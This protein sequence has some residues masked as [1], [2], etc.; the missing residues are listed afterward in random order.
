MGDL[1]KTSNNLLLTNNM[2]LSTCCCTSGTYWEA[3]PCDAFILPGEDCH[4]WDQCPYDERRYINS[5]TRCQGTGVSICECQKLVVRD[6]SDLVVS[7]RVGNFGLNTNFSHA[8]GIFNTGNIIWSVQSTVD[9]SI[10]SGTFTYTD[11][12]TLGSLVD[13]LNNWNPGGL[14]NPITTTLNYAPTGNITKTF[15]TGTILLPSVGSTGDIQSNDSLLRFTWGTGIIDAPF[16]TSSSTF[17]SNLQEA[18]TSTSGLLGINVQQD[19]SN[20]SLTDKIFY[21]TFGGD[22]CGIRQDKLGLEYLILSNTFTPNIPYMVEGTY[23][24]GWGAETTNYIRVPSGDITCPYEDVSFVGLNGVDTG[25]AVFAS[26]LQCCPQKGCILG[27]NQNIGGSDVYK[28]DFA[29]L[30]NTAVFATG[31]FT[32]V[33]YK[34]SPFY[35]LFGKEGRFDRDPS[36]YNDYFMVSSC[37]YSTNSCD[38]D[39]P[40]DCVPELFTTFFNYQLPWGPFGSYTSGIEDTKHEAYKQYLLGNITAGQNYMAD[41][42]YSGWNYAPS[43]RCRTLGTWTSTTG[44]EIEFYYNRISDFYI[45][46]NPAYGDAKIGKI[47][48]ATLAS[49]FTLA[50]GNTGTGT[51][52][53]RYNV[54]GKTVNDFITDVNAI[55]TLSVSG[56]SCYV[57][58]FCGAAPS[59]SLN[60]PCSKINNLSCELFNRWKIEQGNNGTYHVSNPDFDL[61]D[62]SASTILPAPR[63]YNALLATEPKVFNVSS[64]TSVINQPPP[65]SRIKSSGIYPSNTGTIQTQYREYCRPFWTSMRGCDELVATVIKSPSTFDPTVTGFLMSVSGRNVVFTMYS[66]AT[67]IYTTG[68]PLDR[69]GSGYTDDNLIRD[70]NSWTMTYFADGVTTYH[71]LA[72]SSG[73]LPY[74]IYLDDSTWISGGLPSDRGIGTRTSNNYGFINNLKTFSNFDL[75]SGA[76]KRLTS[77]VKNL[78]YPTYDES[79]LDGDLPKCIPPTSPVEDNNINCEGDNIIDMGWLVTYGCNSYTCKTE[80]FIQAKRCSCSTMPVCYDNGGSPIYVDHPYNRDYTEDCGKLSQPTFYMCESNIHP[81]CTI[82]FLIKVPFQYVCA[83]GSTNCYFG[84]CFK[85][86]NTAPCYVA[87]CTTTGDLDPLQIGYSTTDYCEITDNSF[88]ENGYQGWCQYIDPNNLTRVRRRDIPRTWPPKSF[89]VERATTPFCTTNVNP[90]DLGSGPT[91]YDSIGPLWPVVPYNELIPAGYAKEGWPCF[92][93]NLSSNTLAAFIRPIVKDF[94]TSDICTDGTCGKTDIDCNTRCCG[95]GFSCTSDTCNS[96]GPRR[97]CHYTETLSNSQ[98]TIGPMMCNWQAPSGASGPGVCNWG[99]ACACSPPPGEPPPATYPPQIGC[100]DATN[101][102]V[103]TID[104]TRSKGSQVIAGYSLVDGGCVPVLAGSNCCFNVAGSI[105]TNI[106]IV[107]CNTQ[108]FWLCGSPPDR[109]CGGQ[110]E[111]SSTTTISLDCSYGLN[112]YTYTSSSGSVGTHYEC[113][114]PCAGSFPDRTCTAISRRYYESFLSQS[115]T[116]AFNACGDGTQTWHKIEEQ[117]FT[118]TPS[119]GTICGGTIPTLGIYNGNGGINYPGCVCNS[120]DEPNNILWKGTS[121]DDF[122]G[123]YT[124]STLS[125]ESCG[126]DDAT[127]KTYTFITNYQLPWACGLPYNRSTTV[128]S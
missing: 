123:T 34:I 76:S 102:T 33:C 20:G 3:I 86:P 46:T 103:T 22:Q 49:G 29:H 40:C 26:G 77:W 126:F 53:L 38:D 100:L 54:S 109:A 37:D 71:P 74:R 12:P 108:C 39:V 15:S 58:S 64:L 124:V 6:Y 56:N 57:F 119:T 1:L 14:G 60:I 88:M 66:S 23:V 106:N 21:I 8:T 115:S 72:V 111:C 82:P 51:T 81:D 18:F 13:A 17:A 113:D 11:Y 30:E 110:A 48:T 98:T 85:T 125:C 92:M 95:C 107:G 87:K 32:N 28:A 70:L 9:S 24:S 90:F 59:T 36:K 42:A 43:G 45:G 47:D 84:D 62:Y 79:C 105:V 114:D 5:T 65:C 97:N 122:S 117:K 78:C 120:F 10:Q 127:H 52:V 50:S 31:S 25:Y 67:G 35:F 55:K 63:P 16:S 80:W 94:D 99:L 128:I 93:A 41:N 69:N 101:T 61:F 2:L 121:S 4:A 118:G 44:I 73:T 91:K 112:T 68:F 75:L 7:N 104:Y 27:P 19:A 89:I 83:S 116:T 96:T